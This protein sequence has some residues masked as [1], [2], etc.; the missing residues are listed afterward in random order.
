MQNPSNL[1]F[2]LLVVLSL[3][4]G[5]GVR[6]SLSFAKQMWATTYHHTM[7]YA[8][9]PP[10]TMIITTL[11]AGNLALSLGMIGALSIVRF[12][13]PVKSPLELVIFFALITIGIGMSVNVKLG[14]LMTLVTISVILGAKIFENISKKRGKSLFSLSFE[15]GS[16]VNIMEV[17]SLSPIQ[18]LDESKHLVQSFAIKNP[19][20]YNYRLILSD[21]NETKDLKKSIEEKEGVESI[22]VRY[23]P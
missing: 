5:L 8:L 4:C 22:E 13:N 14:V 17:K 10:I 6:F 20:S 19:T 15:E 23:A 18:I 9:L 11:I 7:S 3:I 21:K 1:E 16:N 12:R 2:L